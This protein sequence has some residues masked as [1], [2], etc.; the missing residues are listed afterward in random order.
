MHWFD[1]VAQIIYENNTATGNS[2]LAQGNNIDTYGGGFAHHVYMGASSFAMVWGNDREV[3]TYDGDDAGSQNTGGY[4]SP[5]V[6]PSA[7]GTNLTVAVNDPACAGKPVSGG[8]A[9]ILGGKGAG[10]VRRIISMGV[11]K[12]GIACHKSFMLDKAFTVA[13]D[14]TSALQFEPFRGENIFENQRYVD[15]GGECCA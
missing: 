15:T 10:Q 11:S 4:I 14:A 7:D 13:P 12:T 3:M 2:I 6:P 8:A 1:Q 5:S 9:L